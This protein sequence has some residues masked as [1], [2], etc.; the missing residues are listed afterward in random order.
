MDCKQHD[1]LAWHQPYKDKASPLSRRLAIVQSEIRLILPE[2]LTDSFTVVSLCAG[3]G[4]DLL[5][6]LQHYSD[7]AHVQ[8]RLVELDGRNVAILREKATR[9]GLAHLEIVQ[10]DAADTTLYK[11]I[12]PAD[13]V[14]LCGVFGSISD[15]DIWRT[16]AALP[17]MTK[18]G[19]TVIWT[20]SRR[21]PDLTP[22]IRQALQEMHFTETAFHAPDDVLFSVGACRFQG[23]PQPLQATRL[24]TFKT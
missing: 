19:G 1:W 3:Q 5:G 7:A 6:V 11:G 24:F 4:N 22:R 21:P 18:V 15:T 17:Q 14:L 23:E 8:A 9:A 2:K 10:G 12:V 13:L 16:I 20:R